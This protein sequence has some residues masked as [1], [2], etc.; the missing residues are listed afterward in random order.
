MSC[1]FSQT[2]GRHCIEC[3]GFDGFGTLSE[4]GLSLLKLVTLINEALSE[5]WAVFPQ[6]LWRA[7]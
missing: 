1:Q 3:E 6:V 5:R 4:H 7:F 2:V